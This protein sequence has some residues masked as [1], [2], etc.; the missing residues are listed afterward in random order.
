MEDITVHDLNKVVTSGDNNNTKIEIIGLIIC[1]GRDR[2]SE[3][4]FMR[5]PTIL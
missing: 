4:R 3:A 5:D 2:W 1:S